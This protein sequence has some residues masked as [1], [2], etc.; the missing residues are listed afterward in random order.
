MVGLSRD[1][2]TVRRR[3]DQ[4]GRARAPSPP[5]RATREITV[6][7]ADTLTGYEL[8]ARVPWSALRLSEAPA[9]GT[10]FAMNVNLSDATSAPAT[11]AL[12]TMLSSNPPRTARHQGLPRGWQTIALGD[13]G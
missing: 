6:G 7:R 10:V 12:R 1:A 4:P 3:H 11:G 2:P 8:E 13:A 9:R 5:A